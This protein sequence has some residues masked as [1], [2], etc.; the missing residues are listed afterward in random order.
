MNYDIPIECN[1]H[2]IDVLKKYIVLKQ[3]IYSTIILI[4]MIQYTFQ[5]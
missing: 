3:K 2:E 4:F 1:D 5:L